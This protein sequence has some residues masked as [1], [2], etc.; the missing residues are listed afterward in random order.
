MYRRLPLIAAVMLVATLVTSPARAQD[1]TRVQLEIQRTDDRITQATTIVSGSGNER[2]ELAL[3]NAVS[4]QASAKRSYTSS[5]YAIAL[6]TT[7]DARLRAD[8]AI[9]FVRGQPDP[10]RVHLQIERT[11][12]LLDRARPRIEDCSD[13]RARA[14]LRGAVE[15]QGRAEASLEAQRYIAALRLT[16]SA[17][18]R[19][20]RALRICNLQ[21]DPGDSA[22][23]ALH[24]TDELLDSA[25][26]SLAES[27]P[28][29]GEALLHQALEI[30]AR[31]WAEF[32][33]GHQEAALRLTRSARDMGGRAMRIAGRR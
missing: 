3:S 2:A 8:G 12:E 16:M 29:R 5:Q 23:R 13:D 26:Q 25:R 17:R 21:E 1:P 31:A 9:A 27:A 22:E 30:Q 33:A 7:L 19:G 11:R 15:M 10:E 28:P 6:R 18:E 4:L 20:W 24:R 14:M 32:R